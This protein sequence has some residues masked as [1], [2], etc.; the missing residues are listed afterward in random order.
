MNNLISIKWRYF[1]N[2][3]D[4]LKLLKRQSTAWFDVGT[5]KRLIAT[6]TTLVFASCDFCNTTNGKN[7]ACGKGEYYSDE[8]GVIIPIA[9]RTESAK[10]F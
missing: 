4:N 1:N 8:K 2:F 9:I 10:W 7:S 5:N 6:N 3:T